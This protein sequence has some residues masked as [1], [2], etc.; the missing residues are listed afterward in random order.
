KAVVRHSALDIDAEVWNIGKFYRVIGPRKDGFAQI[1]ADLLSVDVKRSAEFDIANVI[2]AKIDVHQTW[3]ELVFRGVLVI[4]DPLN[5][6]RRAIPDADNCDSN[7]ALT[8]AVRQSECSPAT[9]RVRARTMTGFSPRK[10][11]APT[12]LELKV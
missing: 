1:L 3:N 7:L 4:L 2:A 11:K 8:V 9:A 10:A 6:C 5:E 12:S